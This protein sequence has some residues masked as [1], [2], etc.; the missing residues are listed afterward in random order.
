MVWAVLVIL[1]LAASGEAAKAE[2]CSRPSDAGFIVRT[3]ATCSIWDYSE[4]DGP[5][6]V[7]EGDEATLLKA[8]NLVH[9]RKEEYISVLFYAS[10]CPFSK[11]CKPNFKKLSNLF[12]SIRHFA[13]EESL[14][15]PSILSRYGVHGFPT[16]FL[17]NSTMRIRYHGPRT[18]NALLTFYNDVTSVNPSS[19]DALSVEETV[20]PSE[21]SELTE[22]TEQENCPFTWAR[23]PEKL[24]QQDTYLLLAT[25]FLLSRL[26]YFLF[27]RIKSCVKWVWIRHLRFG[28]LEEYLRAV[29]QGFIGWLRNPCKRGNLSEG[30]INARGNLIVIGEVSTN[31]ERR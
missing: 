25:F 28:N 4:F 11:I 19:L 22:E 5:T 12:P 18:I 13:F 10:W 17:I 21:L 7:A 26:V 27:P 16:L 24:L 2:V 31:G 29:K 6:G 9:K 20:D 1:L 23:S 8:V 3:P 30:A 15:R 14:I